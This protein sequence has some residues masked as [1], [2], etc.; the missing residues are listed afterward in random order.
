[1]QNST[2]SMKRIN[3]VFGNKFEFVLDY[4]IRKQNKFEFVLDLLRVQTLFKKFG[5]FPKILTCHDLH[6]CEFI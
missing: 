6:D 2:S 1:M 4:K 5:T 3:F